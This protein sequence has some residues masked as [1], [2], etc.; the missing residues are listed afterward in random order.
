ME[1]KLTITVVD[2]DSF[3]DVV[4]NTRNL[5]LAQERDVHDSKQ[6]SVPNSPL[7]SRCS[8]KLKMIIERQLSL[9]QSQDPQD[10]Q[11]GRS[12]LNA[13]PYVSPYGSPCSS[14]RIKRKPLKETKRASSEQLGDYVQLNQYKLDRTLGQGNYGLVK[15]AYNR[16]DD[17]NYV[18]QR[19]EESIICLVYI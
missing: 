18:S 3:T 14:P 7:P 11:S 6:R 17:K 13:S 16:E 19:I 10:P 4:E 9:A 15:L 2:M 1:H 8:S 5:S 12:S